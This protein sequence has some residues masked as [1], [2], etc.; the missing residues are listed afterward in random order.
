MGVTAGQVLDDEGSSKIQCGKE[1]AHL[2]V[3]VS[4]VLRITQTELA[5]IIPSKTLHVAIRT[6]RWRL[7][8]RETT[9]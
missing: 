9:N 7:A 1:V 4:S 5:I 3:S 6:L 2:I 8:H